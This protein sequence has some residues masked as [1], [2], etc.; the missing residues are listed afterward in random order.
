M[1]FVCDIIFA[2]DSIM[3]MVMVMMTSLVLF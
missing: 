3:M 1:S 2:S